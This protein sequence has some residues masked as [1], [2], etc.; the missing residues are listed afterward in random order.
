MHNRRTSRF[1]LYDAHCIVCSHLATII[2]DFVA[3]KLEPIS[4]YSPEAHRLLNWVYPQGWSHQ[5]YLITVRDGRP[6]SATGLKMA[7]RLAVLLGIRKG[8]EV[9]TLVRQ[10][11][12]NV[13]TLSRSP[14]S[15]RRRFLENSALFAG[16]TFLLLYGAL[17]LILLFCFQY[18]DSMC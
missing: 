16:G 10:N 9:Y 3:G 5:P 15:G 1:L 2:Q 7:W 13:P 6:C 11:G 4:I 14:L 18:T 17:N 12:I 8:W